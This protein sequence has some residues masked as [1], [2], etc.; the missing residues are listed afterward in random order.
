MRKFL[1]ISTLLTLLISI[2]ANAQVDW[3]EYPDNPVFGENTDAGKPHAQFQS[4]L[5]DADRFSGHG[6]EWLFKMWYETR[7]NGKSAIGVTYSNDGINWT[8]GKIVFK[9]INFG[10]DNDDITEKEKSDDEVQCG[11]NIYPKKPLV[12]YFPDGFT[13]MVDEN[14][15]EDDD[16]G[17]DDGTERKDVKDDK[18]NDDDDDEDD[19]GN[20]VE[21]TMY[22]RMWFF[23]GHLSVSGNNK[24]KEIIHAVS[25]DGEKWYNFEFTQNGSVR[26]VHGRGVDIWNQYTWTFG[27]IIINPDAT[28][29]GDN[30]FDY[31]FAAYFDGHKSHHIV[32][33]AYSEDGITWTGY[34]R[35][36]NGRADPIFTG[37]GTP[38]TWDKHSVIANTV[39]KNDDGTFQMWYS[40]SGGANAEKGLGYATS[41]D[42]IN[43]TRDPYNPIFHKNDNVKWR[44]NETHWPSVLKKDD[45]YKMWYSGRH[46][47]KHSIG[48]ADGCKDG[49]GTPFE[50][51]LVLWLDPSKITGLNGDQ[52]DSWEDQTAIAEDAYMNDEIRKP[53]YRTNAVNG[54]PGVEFTYDYGQTKY[55]FS[56][57]LISPNNYP[58]HN[59]ITT[60]NTDRYYVDAQSKSLFVVFKTGATINDPEE[61][62]EYAEPYYSDG[63]QC[64]FEAGGPMSGFDIY[65]QDG[66]L[67]FG[68]W[69]Y[70]EEVFVIYDPVD[71]EEENDIIYPLTKDQVYLA[72]L[73]Y[74]G[75]TEQYR[76]IV[77]SLDYPE[78]TIVSPIVYFSGFVR[79]MT[80]E[81]NRD[82][83]TGIGCAART[84]YHDYSTGETYSDHFGGIIADVM[85]YNNF[86][87]DD[88]D[89]EHYDGW[90]NNPQDVYDFLND[91]YDRFGTAEGFEYP[92]YD[93]YPQP[94][95]SND[96]IVIERRKQD[97]DESAAKINASPNPF[98]DYSS[99]ELNIDEEQYLI[100]DL[101]DQTGRRILKVYEGKISKGTHKFNIDGSRIPAGVYH[102]RALGEKFSADGQV[103]LKK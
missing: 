18:I 34:D 84:R 24:I 68:M 38:N 4:L 44:Q 95:E 54:F 42:G 81:I 72:H 5:H 14:D 12:K 27:D 98:Q 22:Y 65:L 48:Y 40:G 32:G 51:D 73:E 77:S 43:W 37:S 63:R 59:E 94:K 87:T 66:R 7:K 29:T 11:N 19:D 9:K 90:G 91:R 15:D 13:V 82:D 61:D 62:E 96:W 31:T 21:M 23:S 16:D 97:I 100:I 26:V 52:V 30:P 47:G 75:T 103:T 69:T 102:V 33:L 80:N 3:V 50:P 86:F 35:T 20:K 57:G 67:C 45:C 46:G 2:A 92:D 93:D 6:E 53:V 76:A 74:N 88:P 79:D 41:E 85:L 70:M 49:D 71:S 78:H 58:D 60:G 64:V 28:N 56:D 39:I 25:A 1:L 55:G 99:F 101:F 89:N 10:G 36:G 17:E 83:E 8:N